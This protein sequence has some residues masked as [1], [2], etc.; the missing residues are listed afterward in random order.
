MR[1]LILAWLAVPLVC[2]AAEKGWRPLFNGRDLSGW[3]T[4]IAGKKPGDDP[5]GLAQVRD[6]AIQMYADVAA[7]TKVPFGV[8]TSDDSF[9]RYQPRLEYRWMGKRF[10]PRENGL[11]DAGLL[12][13]VRDASKIWPPSVECQIQEGDTGD[14]IF[15]RGGGITWMNPDPANAPEGQGDA[16]MLPENGGVAQWF[17]SAPKIQPYIGRFEEADSPTGWNRVEVTVQG[18]DYAVHTVNGRTIARLLQMTDE[19]GKPLDSGKICLQLEGAEI[20]YRNVEV[21]EL[22]AP[23]MPDRRTICLSAVT[24]Q[25]ARTR[26]ISIKNS[27]EEGMET[28]SRIAGADAE[29][30]RVVD[31]PKSLGAGESGRWTI[32]F[33]PTRGAGR[34]SAGL[35]IGDEA[36]GAFVVLQG[37]G[38]KAFE[39]ENEPPLQEIV[40]AFGIPLDVGNAKLSLDTKAAIIGDSVAAPYFRAAGPGKVTITPLARFSPKGATPFGYFLKDSEE[41]HELGKMAE[42]DGAFPDAHQALLPP[43]AGEETEVAFEPGQQAF[44]LYMAG[45]KF[46]SFTDPARPT[47]AKI[48]HTARVYPVKSFQGRTMTNAWLVGFEEAANGDYQDLVLMVENA[49]LA[50]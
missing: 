31:A 40:R 47:Q 38:L 5:D 39:G 22:A 26:F 10:A 45:P 15:I 41:L 19:Q 20:A 2:S 49:V 3:T 43:L 37:I 25:L 44:G 7:G 4:T 34:Y 50:E 17:P 13:H 23:L 14:L 48:D 1:S 11:R 24:E 29:A 8:I 42:S 28:P 9:S 21:R 18:A 27:R 33:T 12:Y 6:G 35:Q 16:G 46:T 32:S 30:F 36:D